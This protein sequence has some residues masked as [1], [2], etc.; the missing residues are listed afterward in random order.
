MRNVMFKPFAK[1]PIFEE[2]DRRLTRQWDF[3]GDPAGAIETAREMRDLLSIKAATVDLDKHFWCICHAAEVLWDAK[4]LDDAK[5]LVELWRQT[6]E[7]VTDRA[8]IDPRQA[9]IWAV[10]LSARLQHRLGNYG[11]AASYAQQAISDIRRLADGEGNL[12]A[13]LHFG[14]CN[15]ITEM[16]C[17]ALAIG[18][19]AGRLHFARRPAWRAQFLD[20]WIVDAQLLLDRDLPPRLKRVHGLI[21]QLYFAIAEGP[22]SLE[23]EMWLDRLGRFDDL[24]RPGTPRGQATRRLRSVARARF[25]GDPGREVA[26]S[27]AALVD[28]ARLPRHIERLTANG[29]WAPAAGE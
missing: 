27:K 5:Q 1:L 22:R 25:D 19:P 8:A 29:W 17:A 18:I 2:L 21:I 7:E 14:E 23:R 11:I 9:R 26:E 3:F 16:Y 15:E 10:I 24:C 12:R 20:R 6:V 13:M 28:L 4:Q